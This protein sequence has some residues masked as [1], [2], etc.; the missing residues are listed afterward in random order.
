MR[1]KKNE[2]TV[3]AISFSPQREHPQ[4]IKETHVVALQELVKLSALKTGGLLSL[5]GD[6]ASDADATLDVL[7][8]ARD[9][10]CMGLFKVWV[11]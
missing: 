5:I 11:V 6:A 3:V 1:K 7:R 9:A 2:W 8:V 10:S 4:K